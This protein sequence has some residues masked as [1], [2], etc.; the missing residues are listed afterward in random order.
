MADKS[1]PFYE[2]R[3]FQAVVAVVALLGAIWALTGAPTP[4]KI[5]DDLV[6][7]DL[8]ATNTLLVLD[9]SAG[10]ERSFANSTTRFDAAARAVENFTVPLEN[11][12][13]ALRTFGG[14]CDKRNDLVV[15]FGAEHGDDVRDA[16]ADQRPRGHSNLVN[17]V[18]AAIDDFA[19]DERFPQ[20]GEKRIVIFTGTVDDCDGATSAIRD[21]LRHSGVKAVFKVV[22]IKLKKKDRRR[23]RAFKRGLGRTADIAFVNKPSDF[24]AVT[25][26]AASDATSGGDCSDGVDNDG[27]AKTDEAEDEDC[28]VDGTE[29]PAPSTGDCADGDD[30]DHDG[31][32]DAAEDED[33]AVDNTEASTPSAGDCAD[34]QDNDHDGKTDAAEDED[35][36]VDNTEASAAPT[37]DCAD[38][39]DNDHDGKT[40]AAEDEDCAV[41]NTEAA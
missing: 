40:D 23:L 6:T 30:N 22:G 10:M 29:A 38:G 14:A 26:W 12:G 2:S 7:N 19:D 27:D 35:C 13:L 3:R 17:A 39:Q 4:W 8:P 21:D 11:E 1:P 33:C 36:A 24:D 37:G 20:G 18:R 28:E 16:I 25:E 5:V 32:T 41:D 15:D 31:K 9:A 34:G